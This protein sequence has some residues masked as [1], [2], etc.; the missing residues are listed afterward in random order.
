MSIIN[1]DL[2][3]LDAFAGSGIA[4]DTICV[5]GHRPK[6]MGW[7]YDLGDRKWMR[8]RAAF[9]EILAGTGC[10]DAWT[11]MALGVDTVFAN[12][13]LDLKNAGS[14]IRLHCAIP[15]HGQ[16]SKWRAESVSEYRAILSRA[17]ET[18][19]VSPGGF[20]G[21]KMTERDKFMVGKASLVVAVWNG[22]ASGTGRC[23]HDAD[24]RGK[25]ILRI[26]PSD[27]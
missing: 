21:W 3:N 14:P 4:A 9:R 6:S 2:D 26:D 16:E 7:T 25:A 1:L 19:I 24:A 20:A 23:V 15:F 5:T 8:L 13:V 18:V 10:K 17:D 11:G 27:I 12:A 22:S